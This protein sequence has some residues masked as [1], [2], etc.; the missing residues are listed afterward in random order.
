MLMEKKNV[1]VIGYGAL[2][3][4]LVKGILET[5]SDCCT[6]TGVLDKYLDYG[7]EPFKKAYGSI[8]ELLA[9]H[10]DYVVEIASQEAVRDYG[11]KIL[12]SGSNLIITSVGS[13]ADDQLYHE[14]YETAAQSGT[15]VHVTSGAVGGFDVMQTIRAMGGARGVIRNQKAPASL[16]GAPYLNGRLLSETE[17]ELVFQ[18]TAREAIKGFPKN[19]NVAVASAIASVGVDEM[20]VVI[21]SKP[22]LKDNVHTVQIEND[23][24]KATVQ[25]ASSPDKDNP[26]SSVMTAWSVIALLR[27]LSS[28]IQLF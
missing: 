18:G 1:A 15:L 17:E 24:V 25:I 27:N 10:P 14:L 28:P 19:V 5:L 23:T 16:N 9:E 2:G 22:G 13:L 21:E 26:K 6:L 3:R 4:I 12:R 11:S 8:E 7:E 20:Q